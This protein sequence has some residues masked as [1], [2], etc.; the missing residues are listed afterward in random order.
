VFG[1]DGKLVREVKSSGEFVHVDVPG[2]ADG[3]LWSFRQ[4]A[5]GHLWFFNCPNV[6]AGS[7]DGLLL[8]RDIVERDGL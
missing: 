8:P 6:L 4:L 2:G 3:K 7:A 1:P 5:L